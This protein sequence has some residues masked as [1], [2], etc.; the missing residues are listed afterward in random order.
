MANGIQRQSENQTKQKR[1]IILLMNS[2][3]CSINYK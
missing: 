1:R 3:L 2:L